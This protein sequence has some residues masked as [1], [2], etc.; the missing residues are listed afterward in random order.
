MNWN[1]PCNTTHPC[2]IPLS[3]QQVPQG[4]R[5]CS[6]IQ[7]YLTKH[8]AQI[9]GDYCLKLGALSAEVAYYP[10]DQHIIVDE[11]IPQNLTALSQCPHI[12][13]VQ[14]RPTALPFVEGHFSACLFAHGLHF[15]AN[16]H[17]VL[18]EITR[19]LNQEGILFL[20]LFNPFSVFSLKQYFPF[21]KN[22]V[23]FKPYF[24]TRIVD[25][26]SLLNFELLDQQCLSLQGQSR[27]FGDIMMIVA[28]KRTLPMT[29]NAQR[30]P[31]SPT[32]TPTNAFQQATKTETIIKTNSLK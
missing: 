12:E 8:F 29:L 17:Q 2:Q 19:T 4:A 14:A 28:Q 10:C 21:S 27:Y 3:W 6:L 9:T 20:S 24:V 31:F 13:L 7:Q 25:W 30:S 5:Y 11:K 16:P 18:R 32:L 26:L 15:T 22:T 1:I 23:F